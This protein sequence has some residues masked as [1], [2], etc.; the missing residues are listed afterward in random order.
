MDSELT[1]RKLTSVDE[2]EARLL[3]EWRND[4]F[5]RNMSLSVDVVSWP[6]HFEWYKKSLQNPQRE[7]YLFFFEA[8]PVGMGRLDKSDDHTV[9]S[10]AVSPDHRKRGYGKM[11]VRRLCQFASGEK[12][13]LI[14]EENLASQ[15]IAQQ[16]GFDLERS[17]DG[18]CYY[19][20]QRSHH[21]QD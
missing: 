11:I 4:P 2:E 9:L 7:I 5:T 1:Y 18:I 20:N 19:V 10:W 21:E 6:S 15:K 8:Q 12:R 3:F 14:K 13:A 17:Q 16:A